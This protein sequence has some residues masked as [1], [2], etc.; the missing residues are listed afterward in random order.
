MVRM[1][2]TDGHIGSRIKPKWGKVG[3]PGS[4]KRKRWLKHI[5]RRR[6]SRRR[7]W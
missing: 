7:Q 2:R 3:A 1:M 5:R 6:R 4:K